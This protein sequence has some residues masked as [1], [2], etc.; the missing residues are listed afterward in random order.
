MA[1][2]DKKFQF[3]FLNLNN[4]QLMT[5]SLNNYFHLTK[6]LF[7]MNTRKPRIKYQVVKMKMRM[8]IRTRVNT[9]L[10][11]L[12]NFSYLKLVSTNK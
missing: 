1:Y 9:L 5:Q 12:F 11:F 7:N 8:E 6:V 4:N 10:V 2:I 3:Y